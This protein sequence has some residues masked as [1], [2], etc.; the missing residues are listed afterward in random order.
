[1]IEVISTLEEKPQQIHYC[2]VYDEQTG[3]IVSRHG[4]VGDGTGLFGVDGQAERARIALERAKQRH[5]SAP[6]RVM[7]PPRDFEFEPDVLHRVDVKHGK[8]VSVGRFTL[9]ELME[10]RKKKE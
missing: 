10:R 2:V 5:K 8:L 6:L 7:H 9:T 1:M 3:A 4:F